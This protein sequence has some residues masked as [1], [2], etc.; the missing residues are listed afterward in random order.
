MGLTI[1]SAD[2]KV[3]RICEFYKG[4]CEK[5]YLSEFKYYCPSRY[6][7]E[8]RKAIEK[9]HEWEKMMKEQDAINQENKDSKIEKE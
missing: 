2:P 5:C 3:L 6:V 9:M 4:D 1:F 7:R 8:S